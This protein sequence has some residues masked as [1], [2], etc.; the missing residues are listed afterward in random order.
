MFAPGLPV[1]TYQHA[2][3]NSRLVRRGELAAASPG[4]EVRRSPTFE[5]EQAGRVC[6]GDGTVLD[7]GNELGCI[8]VFWYDSGDRTTW[9]R[10]SN[11]EFDVIT[12]IK[13][14]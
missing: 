12:A 14:R 3:Q 4:L 9:T 2:L 7:Y 10:A 5:G 6:D 13:E 1:A 11:G 8:A